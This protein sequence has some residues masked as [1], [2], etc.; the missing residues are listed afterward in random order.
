MVRQTLPR[1]VS[2]FVSAYRTSDAQAT[3]GLTLGLSFSFGGGRT[4][5]IGVDASN[6]GSSAYAE[7]SKDGGQAPGSL[8]WRM[9]AEG[10]QDTDL[11]AEVGYVAPFARGDLLVQHVDGVTA[12]Q[13]RMDGAVV[14]MGGKVGLSNRIDDAFAVID[15]GQAKV[16]V[17]LENR[18][19]GQT[20]S[21]GRLIVPYLTSLTPNTI[22]IDADSL[23]G[24]VIAPV[25]E[26]QA[27]PDRASG[28]M[29][30]FATRHAAVGALIVLKTA[31]GAALPVGSVGRF[32][33]GPPALVVGY[34]GQ[35]YVED[36]PAGAPL[37][38]TEPSGAVCTVT[39]E[40]SG[41]TLHASTCR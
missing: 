37:S 22:A 4:A 12:V 34:D 39:L 38:L 30:K 23:P 7:V 26:A 13:G 8:S 1:G 6:T 24:D 18:I 20:G 14:L 3:T 5:D 27:T 36:P 41:P 29:V 33:D 11:E 2:M 25:V 28:V 10:G 9:H 31:D 35:A 17:L 21:D 15:A 16:P 19:V 32:G 40:G